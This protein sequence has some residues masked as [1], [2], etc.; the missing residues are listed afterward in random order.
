[1]ERYTAEE[2]DGQIQGE[3]LESRIAEIDNI[4]IGETSIEVSE[5]KF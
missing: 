5:D 4:E 3:A 1:M 2:V